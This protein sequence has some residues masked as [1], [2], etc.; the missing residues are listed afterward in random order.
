MEKITLNLDEGTNS[1][2]GEL[3]ETSIELILSLK[4]HGFL[5]NLTKS[6]IESLPNKFNVTIH[7]EEEDDINIDY[8]VFFFLDVKAPKMMEISTQ[9][10][11]NRD[12]DVNEDN[13]DLFFS[14]N[15]P[16]N[17]KLIKKTKN[18]IILSL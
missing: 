18:Q 9:E 2:I 16:Q 4:H 12:I 5:K 13:G 8:S 7:I 1:L 3:K 14:L 15:I 6:L 10:Y 17:S 11:L